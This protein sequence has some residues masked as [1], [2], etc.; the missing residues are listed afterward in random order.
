M[1]RGGEQEGSEERVLPFH[2]GICAHAEHVRVRA[3]C[4]MRAARL[5]KSALA[6]PRATLCASTFL[7]VI[8]AAFLKARKR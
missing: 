1:R 5:D 6:S 4:A 8:V 7:Q 2:R 3:V